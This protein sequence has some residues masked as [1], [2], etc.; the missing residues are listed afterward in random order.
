MIVLKF[1]GSSVANAERIKHVAS[2][3]STK[4]EQKLVVVSALKGVTDELKGF[5]HSSVEAMPR[6]E[7]LSLK[8]RHLDLA[9]ELDCGN[10]ELSNYIETIF[11]QIEK[12]C[13][14][15]HALGECTERIEA[16]VMGS[17]EK[18]S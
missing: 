14:G 12:I 15:I 11:N 6:S 10:K 3:I 16:L 18:L 13:L 7:I 2:I 4:P 8:Q 17:G 5:V 9:E 1:G